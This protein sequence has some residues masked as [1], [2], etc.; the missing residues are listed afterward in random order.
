MIENGFLT[1]RALVALSSPE[2]LRLGLI[3]Y[4]KE[5][6]L[7]FDEMM[8]LDYDE[9]DEDTAFDPWMVA[10]SIFQ[11]LLFSQRREGFSEVE[12]QHA[13]LTQEEIEEQVAEFLASLPKEEE[14]E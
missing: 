11:Y 4:L 2:R 3:E 12:D 1:V 8:N 7:Q 13:G 5:L 14:N 9:V 6:E 10:D